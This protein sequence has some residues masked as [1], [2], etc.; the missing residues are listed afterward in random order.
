MMQQF[1]TALINTKSKDIAKTMILYL[2]QVIPLVHPKLK[3]LASELCDVMPDIR[4]WMWR[5]V[6]HHTAL[7]E[8]QKPKNC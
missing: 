1:K 5:S 7:L 6:L 4:R 3:I 2:I 8:S